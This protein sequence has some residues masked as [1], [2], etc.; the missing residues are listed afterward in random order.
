MVEIEN[1][2]SLINKD[3]ESIELVTFAEWIEDFERLANLGVGLILEP[4]DDVYL[5]QNQL[6]LIDL[7]ALDFSNF[8]DGRV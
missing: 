6:D 4:G 8:D 7:I 1:P 3:Y 5:I 2:T